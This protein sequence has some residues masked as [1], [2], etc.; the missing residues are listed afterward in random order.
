MK[1]IDSFSG[2]YRVLS[3]FYPC[4]IKFEG[5]KYPSVEHAFQAA[6]TLNQTQRESIRDAHTPAE[7]KAL[8][9]MVRL[10]RDWDVTKFHVMRQCLSL[11]F[12]YPNADG[13][14]NP[15]SKILLE[16][17]SA[18]LIEGNTWGDRIWGVYEGV[19]ENHLGKMLM[20]RRDLLIEW[21]EE[22]K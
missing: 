14:F 11:K 19:G 8:G 16:T 20:E 12:P 22:N 3:N 18:E 9:K 15:L 2:N 5:L 10:R 13:E 4:L 17:G 6:K 21:C 1:V 7:A